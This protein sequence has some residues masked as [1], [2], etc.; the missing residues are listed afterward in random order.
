[1][2]YIP[3]TLIFLVAFAI[4]AVASKRLSQY[5]QKLKLPLITGFIIVGVVTGPYFLN[6]VTTESVQNLGFINDIA[7]AFIAFAAGTELFLKEIRSKIGNIIRMTISQLVVTFAVSFVIIILLSKYIPFFSGLPY[8]MVVS[9]SILVST[10]FIARSPSSFIAIINEIRA[11]GP[12]TKTALGVTVIVDT[13]VI[14]IFSINF[15][16]VNTIISGAN[17]DLQHIILIVVDLIISVFLGF[18]IF[19]ILEFLLSLRIIPFITMV[20]FLLIG[21]GIFALTDIVEL[22]SSKYLPYTFHIEPLL[23]GLVAGFVLTNYSK[24]R[25][26]LQ[27]IIE[28]ASPYVYVAFFTFAGISISIDILIESWIIAL[29]FFFVRIVAVII[30]TTV[31]GIIN[32]IP[33]RHLIVNWSAYIT[34]AGVSFGLIMLI[35]EKFPSWGSELASILIAVVV[36]N[37]FIGPPL[38]KWAIG[39]VGESHKK[40]KIS[41]F[42]GNRD[43]II[44]GFEGASITLAKVLKQ[45]NWN[46]KL[47]TQICDIPKDTCKIVDVETIPDFTHENL[48]KLKI[49]N[50]ETIVLMKSDE[51]NYKICELAYEKFAVPNI[52]VQL[53]N[54]LDFNKFRKL[55]AIVVEPSTAI[56]SLLDHFVRSPK[57]TS[58]LLGTDSEKD[59]TDIEI[60]DNDI[61]GLALRDIRF[62]QDI[63]VLSIFRNNK[64]ITSHGYTVLKK[65]DIITVLG[66]EKSLEEVRLK[67]Q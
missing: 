14:L 56:I 20:I 49:E 7:L 65:H 34:Q 30:S 63:L 4:I 41:E 31:G 37:Q 67:F 42:T 28:K 1:M 29:V 50:A 62:P 53:S 51:I 39:F 58:V 6:L 44:F 61:H 17:F 16:L 54:R 55:D 32:K 59:T 26:N 9:I 2:N 25:I 24:Y 40:A 3:E 57:A 48:K 8:P 46:V 13:I 5:F 23:S 64:L 35:A 11:K 21:W 33:K 43:V 52:I 15:S 12:F 66:S 27:M 19:K 22:T 38:L 47:V 10:I 60:L 45:H 18:V 36:L